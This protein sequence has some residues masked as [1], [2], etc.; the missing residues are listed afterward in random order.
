MA[1]EWDIPIN[2]NLVFSDKV[3]TQILS[4]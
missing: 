4:S 1:P 2:P 3:E